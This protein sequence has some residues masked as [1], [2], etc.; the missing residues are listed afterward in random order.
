[1][2]EKGTLTFVGLGVRSISVY[3]KNKAI[4]VE[5][6]KSIFKGIFVGNI[7]VDFDNPIKTLKFNFLYEMAEPYELEVSMVKYKEPEIDYQS[8]YLE[9]M[10]IDFAVGES[11]VNIYFNKAKSEI[12]KIEIEIYKV[13]DSTNIRLI[14]KEKCDSNQLYY[15]KNN[16]AFGKYE[17]KIIQY[18]DDKIITASPMISFSL[19]RPKYPSGRNTVTL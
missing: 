3:T 6:V 10:N 15:S 16:L 18:I 19:N 9:N 2:D 12:N 1:M 8:I 7:P 14:S 5:L 13:I 4:E 17:F 11:L